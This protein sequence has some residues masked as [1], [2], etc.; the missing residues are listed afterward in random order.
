MV[1]DRYVRVRI[2][3]RRRGHAV[4]GMHRNSLRFEPTLHEMPGSGPAM[5]RF[6]RSFVRRSGLRASSPMEDLYRR[7]CSCVGSLNC[8]K[9]FS[10][11][12]GMRPTLTTLIPGRCGMYRHGSMT[13][14][15]FGKSKSMKSGC[16]V[17]I[18]RCWPDSWVPLALRPR[19]GHTSRRHGRAPAKG[20]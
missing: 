9:F 5:S 14:D 4:C 8:W 12:R 7:R 18:G 10:Q 11:S 16:L 19:R 2:G 6:V 13:I 15:P 20:S 3:T 17:P 1:A